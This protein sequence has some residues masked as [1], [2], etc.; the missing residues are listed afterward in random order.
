ML[1]P[2]IPYPVSSD[3][4]SQALQTMYKI[5]TLCSGNTR[6]SEKNGCFGLLVDWKN[7]NHLTFSVQNE[8]KCL[9]VYFGKFKAQKLGVKNRSNN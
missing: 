7:N 4:S 9:R 3:C 1:I 2:L 6:I 8:T 5:S